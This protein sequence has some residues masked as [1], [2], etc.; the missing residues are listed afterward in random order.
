MKQYALQGYHDLEFLALG[1]NLSNPQAFSTEEYISII[2]DVKDMSRS[3]ESLLKELH[4][5][6][7]ER[8]ESIW[9]KGDLVIPLSG[10]VDSR[11]LLSSA[12]ELTESSN[13]ETFTFGVE[14]SLDYKLG[15]LTA[16]AAGTMHHK[17]DLDRHIFNVD[18]ELEYL[19][20]VN[21][22]T[23]A[24][25]HPPFEDFSDRYNGKYILS[26]TV[27]DVFFGRHSLR[28]TA[29]ISDLQEY[30]VKSAYNQ[31]KEFKLDLDGLK[32]LRGS[33]DLELALDLSV[34]QSRFVLPHICTKNM[35]WGTML[36]DDLV[37]FALSLPQE[38]KLRQKL[39]L[40]YARNYHSKLFQNN[41]KSNF[42]YNI[43]R[44]FITSYYLRKFDMKISSILG[45]NRYVNYVNWE[46]KSFEDVSFRKL[47]ISCLS[48]LSLRKLP[49]LTTHIELANQSLKYKLKGSWS[50]VHALVSLELN[51]RIDE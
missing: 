51:L 42:L 5:L 25:L 7:M 47:L 17:Y 23:L 20:N 6:W 9:R 46:S 24:F 38:E 29:K 40:D 27:I 14:G 16:R 21:G 18:E 45:L 4:I 39:Y 32:S 3:H 48:D 12:M 44:D 31:L 35:K 50:L 43:N 30:F 41:V 34:R 33:K 2:N 36:S 26:G 22:R 49:Y 10:G 11:L 28:S 15:N 37:R 19:R 8:V 1:Y 13:L